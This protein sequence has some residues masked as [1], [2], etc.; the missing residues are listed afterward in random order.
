MHIPVMP[1]ETV[2]LLSIRPDGTY[3]DGTLGGGGHSE[4]ILSR[5]NE[6]GCLISIDRDP[7][8]IERA[9]PRMEGYAG[10]WLPVHSN[11]AQMCEAAAEAGVP[12]VDGVL[13][14]LGFS[15]DQVDDARRGFSFMQDGPLD[16]RMDT[17]QGFCAADL[18]N[19]AEEKVLA[20]LIFEFGEERNARRI[21]RAIV[22]A[23][24]EKP[25]ATTAQL[26][27]LIEKI[28]PR[29]GSRIHPA[30]R[31]FQA[32]RM[33]VNREM[34]SLEEGLAAALALTRPGGRIAVITFHSL[35]DRYV[36]RVFRRHE[37][38]EESL[39]QGGVR[40]V[41]DP[42]AVRRVTRKPVTASAAEIAENPR[43][44]SAKLRVVEVSGE[45]K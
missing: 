36:K 30:T 24:Q 38:K 6:Q 39:P 41:F 37:V 11:F 15:S 34:E 25:F 27:E 40:R 23:R 1:A 32:L 26:A 28:C 21:A 33:A 12:A 10:R 45:E 20:D 31:T 14:D 18:V 29:R 35:E 22:G 16:M 4:M 5:L 2:D 13:M 43:A 19:T 9:R 17:T 8:A 42:P 3:I 44:R 7:A